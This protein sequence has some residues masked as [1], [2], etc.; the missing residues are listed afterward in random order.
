MSAK[1]VQLTNQPDKQ[2]SN[3]PTKQTNKPFS[4]SLKLVVSLQ[5]LRR[6]RCRWGLGGW[7]LGSIVRWL[8]GWFHGWMDGFWVG[9]LH[10][11][12]DGFWIAAGL[13]DELV[14]G[15]MYY[16]LA[17]KSKDEHT[18]FKVPMGGVNTAVCLACYW[19]NGTHGPGLASRC[20]S[21]A[22]L[23]CLVVALTTSIVGLSF[24]GCWSRAGRW[25]AVASFS[26]L[27]S[28]AKAGSL[29]A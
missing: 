20:N 7:L 27:A 14:C 11:L 4:R 9:G 23:Q 28:S 8:V 6:Q 5:F 12:L 10:G 3:Q 16:N 15:C 17:Q 18:R 19:I 1:T 22:C 2:R 24:A 26:A 13:A 21:H 29:I 25:Q